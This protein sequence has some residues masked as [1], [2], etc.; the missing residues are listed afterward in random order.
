MRD[1]H[2]RLTSSALHK[3]RLHRPIHIVTRAAACRKKER[4]TDD[5]FTNIWV[6][7]TPLLQ[8]ELAFNVYR[9]C[10]DS[11][12]NRNASNLTS[13]SEEILLTVAAA[14]A[15]VMMQIS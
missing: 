9:L 12:T 5:V 3:L 13:R 4:K 14:T 8:K 15:P 2:R 7:I 6:C 11:Q 10:N 1:H